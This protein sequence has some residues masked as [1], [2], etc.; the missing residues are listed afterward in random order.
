M[1]RKS[2]SGVAARITALAICVLTLCA[3]ATTPGWAKA[4]TAKQI[5]NKV[6]KLDPRKPSDIDVFTSE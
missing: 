1:G 4:L 2:A 5:A 3:V 6:L